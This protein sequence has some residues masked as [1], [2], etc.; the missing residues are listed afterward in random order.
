MAVSDADVFRNVVLGVGPIGLA[1]AKLLVEQGEPVVIASRHAPSAAVPCPHRAVDARDP[2]ALAQLLPEEGGRLFVCSAPGY[3]AWRVEYMPM[4]EGI[5]AAVG[6]RRIDLIYADNM[7]AYGPVDG[8]VDERTPERAQTVKGAIR[9]AAARRLSELHGSAGVRVVIA[10]AADLYG[11]GV[12]HSAL[13]TGV[14]EAI[15]AGR[16]ANMLGDPATRHS[17][18][19][20]PDFAAALVALAATQRAWGEIW[21]VPNAPAQTTTAI[22]DRVAHACGQNLRL[23]R[24]G[25]MLVAALGLFDPQMR[26]LKEMLYLFERPFVVSHDKYAAAFGDGATPLDRGVAQTLAPAP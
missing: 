8:V 13:G 17:Y 10:R 21:H 20:A 11:P 15:A 2:A 6:G 19:Y 12:V 5:A 9:R 22:L 24:A 3:T 18:T 4:I 26:E 7:Y 14:F 16:P 25:R 1:V 23:R